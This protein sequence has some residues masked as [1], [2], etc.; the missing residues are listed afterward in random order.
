MVTSAPPSGVN[1]HIRH[2][3]LN[4]PVQTGTQPINGLNDLR[5]VHINVITCSYLKQVNGREIAQQLRGY[6]V[7]IKSKLEPQRPYQMFTLPVT[8]LWGSVIPLTSVGIC[9]MCIYTNTYTS[10]QKQ[11]SCKNRHGTIFRI[12]CHFLFLCMTCLCLPCQD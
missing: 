11:L 7:L 2:T 10:N 9:T 12:C 1:Q 4:V 3:C 6:T 5:R 8:Q